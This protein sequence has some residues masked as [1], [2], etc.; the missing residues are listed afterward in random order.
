MRTSAGQAEWT[1]GPLAAELA[2]SPKTIRYY[3]RIGLL[4]APR[5][6]AAG[7]RV[8]GTAE[9][10]RLR[11]ILKAKS[12]GLT[13]DEIGTV[14]GVRRAGLQ[15][16][17]RVLQLLDQKLGAV[18]EQLQALSEYRQELLMIR[19]EAEQTSHVTAC[20]CGIIEQHESARPGAAQKAVAVLTHR[21]ISRRR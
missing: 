4:P 3:G 21:P 9:R 19:Q 13:L 5:R 11:F 18:N 15:P 6:T 1:I 2:V 7:Y 16:C 10:D 14:F 8:Y 17:T 12:I 20:V